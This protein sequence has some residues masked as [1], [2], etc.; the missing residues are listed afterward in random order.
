MKGGVWRAAVCLADQIAPLPRC[1]AEDFRIRRLI[2]RCAAAPLDEDAAYL[3]LDVSDLKESHRAALTL[4]DQLQRRAQGYLMAVT[5]ASSFTLSALALLVKVQAGRSELVHLSEM[6]RVILLAALG[7]F[8]MSVVSALRVLGPS[9]VYD[10]WLRS[11][12]PSDPEQK[13]ANLIRFTRLN[14]SYA[15]V[16]ACHVR[17]S[18]LAMRNGVL[19]VFAWLAALILSPGLLL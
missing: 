8:M 10:L 13:K 1:V 6:T 7:S 16:Y 2:R 4:R 12:F 14:E 11:Q 5:I 9:D 18:Y 19:L 3:A 17:G 15:L